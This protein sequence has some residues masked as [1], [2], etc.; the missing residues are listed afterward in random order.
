MGSSAATRRGSLPLRTPPSPLGKRS[1]TL[2]DRKAISTEGG[3]YEKIGHVGSG[4]DYV[5]LAGLFHGSRIGSTQ[6]RRDDH[7]RYQQGTCP[8]ESLGQHELHRI[9][10]SRSHV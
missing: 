6:A 2:Y 8:D 4:I 1:R 10:H 7:A 3:L 9:A 5:P